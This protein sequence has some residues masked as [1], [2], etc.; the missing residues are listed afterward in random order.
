MGALLRENLVLIE[1]EFDEFQRFCRQKGFDLSYYSPEISGS[2]KDIEY[3]QFEN[4]KVIKLIRGWINFRG[5]PYDVAEWQRGKWADALPQL[6]DEFSKMRGIAQTPNNDSAKSDKDDDRKRKWNESWGFFRL[7][8]TSMAT[9]AL[10][11]LVPSQGRVLPLASIFLF[12]ASVVFLTADL[13]RFSKNNEWNNIRDKLSW[14][15]EL[16]APIFIITS[17]V[18][19]IINWAK[20]IALLYAGTSSNPSL[21]L[22]W[23]HN[24]YSHALPYWLIYFVLT[25]GASVI[26]TEKAIAGKRPLNQVLKRVGL[27]LI[28]AILIV[29]AYKL[30]LTNTI[31]AGLREDLIFIIIFPIMFVAYFLIRDKHTA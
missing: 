9:G 3:H 25:L 23:V 17:I 2:K 22:T 15:G 20:I 1:S 28:L 11:I 8:A 6:K 16:L 5:V 19:I 26:R 21:T 24:F 7:A 13:S 12:L 18:S 27:L 30:E 4:S 31:D 14:Y 10:I 29:V